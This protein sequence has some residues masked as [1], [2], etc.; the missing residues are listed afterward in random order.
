VL[1]LPSHRSR[2]APPPIDILLFDVA[3]LGI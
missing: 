2:P 3:I 1:A